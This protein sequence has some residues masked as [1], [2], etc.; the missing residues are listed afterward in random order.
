MKITMPQP[1]AEIKYGG[2]AS[3]N[4]LVWTKGAG[5]QFLPAGTKLYAASVHAPTPVAYL[6][7]GAGGYMYLGTDLTEDQVGSFPW[8]RHILAIVGTYGADGYVPA[9]WPF[10]YAEAYQV[11][12]QDLA[13]WKRRALE[14]ELR[15]RDQ[16][17]IIDR[18][19]DDLNAING[20][21]FMGEPLLPKQ[22]AAPAASDV[23]QLLNDL[24]EFF[25]SSGIDPG[26]GIALRLASALTAPQP[27]APAQHSDDVAVDRFA[28]AMKAKL[29]AARAKGRSGWDDPSACSIEYL[30]Q[31]L[32]EH[33]AK[34]NAGTFEDVANFC[35]MLHQRG[36][37]PAVLAAPAQD[38]AG[39]V[40]AARKADDI[41]AALTACSKPV[42][43]LERDLG[44]G[45]REGI[46]HVRREITTALAAH[47]QREGE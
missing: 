12:Q 10:D 9:E 27:A 34:G 43:R 36:A 13:I 28:A 33:L 16:D 41:L 18:M 8:G 25:E 23:G 17:Q 38:V 19:G 29:A 7:V 31:L 32:R 14:A 37:D 44:K 40:E 24:F 45:W 4:E 2:Y 5:L 6:D 46:Y 11:A 21:T 26:N 42:Y 39:L 47:Q 20:P 35:M 30:A 15:V 22:S 3:G 1:V